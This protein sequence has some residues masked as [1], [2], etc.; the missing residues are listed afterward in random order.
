MRWPFTSLLPLLE[1]VA[2]QRVGAERRPMINSARRGLIS[3]SLFVLA[4][5]FR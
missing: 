3:P 2:R 5:N 4:R 1:K